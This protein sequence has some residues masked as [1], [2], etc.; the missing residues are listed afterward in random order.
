MFVIW[1]FRQICAELSGSRC[2]PN[3]IGQTIIYTNSCVSTNGF[4]ALYTTTVRFHE[5]LDYTHRLYIILM[6]RQTQAH[7][8]SRNHTYTH[9][10]HLLC[11]QANS[12]KRPTQFTPHR[13]II[14]ALKQTKHTKT[15]KVANPPLYMMPLRRLF[16]LSICSKRQRYTS[17]KT[18]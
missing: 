13:I 6:S 2:C 17:R 11:F 3:I 10:Q 5:L 9:E 15:H 8:H 12:T 7:T 1:W 14:A 4:S 18:N 16:I